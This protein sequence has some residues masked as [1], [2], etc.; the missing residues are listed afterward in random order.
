MAATA[1][2]EV[3]LRAVLAAAVAARRSRRTPGTA[4]TGAGPLVL[5]AAVELR[6]CHR[7][8]GTAAMALTV[9]C[10]LRAIKHN[11]QNLSNA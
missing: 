9:A 4:G 5:V 2:R 1:Q 8:R 10:W 11:E 7:H 3:S 6:S